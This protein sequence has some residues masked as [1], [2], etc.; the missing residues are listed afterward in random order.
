MGSEGFSFYLKE[1]PG[2]FMILGGGNKKKGYMY[3][4][5]SNHFTIDEDCLPIGAAVYSQV[6]CDFLKS[7]PTL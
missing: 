7:F 6:A 3:S 5:H 1:V 4:Q 2:I